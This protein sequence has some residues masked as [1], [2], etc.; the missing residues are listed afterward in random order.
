MCR[1]M[2][3]GGLVAQGKFLVKML[4]LALSL[5]NDDVK[6]TETLTK[7]AESHSKRGIKSVEVI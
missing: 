4:S 3:T 6:L 5:A 7:L 2:F 1:P